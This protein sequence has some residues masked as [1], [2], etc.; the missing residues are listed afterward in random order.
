MPGIEPV[1]ISHMG[2]VAG[3]LRLWF[4]QD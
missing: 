2:T 1:I 3:F 4:A